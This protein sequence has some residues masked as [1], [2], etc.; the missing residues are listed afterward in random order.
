MPGRREMTAMAGGTSVAGGG[1]PMAGEGTEE[2]VGDRAPSMNGDHA[3]AGCAAARSSSG[4]TEGGN[5][6]RC[7]QGSRR[8]QKGHCQDSR[9]HQLRGC[10]NLEGD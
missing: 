8:D 9:G 6:N 10:C 1:A 4:G 2:N 3:E 7:C 5:S